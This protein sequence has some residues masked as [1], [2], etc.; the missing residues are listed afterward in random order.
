MDPCYIVYRQFQSRSAGVSGNTIGVGGTLNWRSTRRICESLRVKDRT[1]MDMGAGDG[2]FMLS[3]LAYGA[4][5]VLRCEH[6]QNH[7]QSLI[8]SS[9]LEG[10]A[11]VLD[12]LV[13]EQSV[14]RIEYMLQD[15]DQALACV[16]F[17]PLN[18]QLFDVFENLWGS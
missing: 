18:I 10:V 11:Q 3:A 4:R 13:F 7:A 6:P 2:Q 16:S 5:K 15:I 9:A 12:G 14:S 17:L 8:L 1:V